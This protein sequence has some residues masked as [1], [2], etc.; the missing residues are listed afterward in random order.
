MRIVAAADWPIGA[1]ACA[2]DCPAWG[3]IM[4]DSSGTTA[5][6]PSPGQR[7]SGWTRPH[8]RRPWSGFL[9]AADLVDLVVALRSE[10]LPIAP[11]LLIDQLA[12]GRIDRSPHR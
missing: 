10:S 7:L 4:L 9:A 6:L 2:I 5:S 11:E 1:P 3:S 8:R 12:F